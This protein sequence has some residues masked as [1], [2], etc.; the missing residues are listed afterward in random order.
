MCKYKNTIQAKNNYTATNI[1]YFSTTRYRNFWYQYQP[2]NNID[3]Y[4]SNYTIKAIL[5]LHWS[6]T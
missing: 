6:K 4:T 3:K 1:P 2:K 5:T